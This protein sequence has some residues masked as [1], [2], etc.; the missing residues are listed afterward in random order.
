[1]RF[2]NAGWCGNNLL[3]LKLGEGRS[4]WF[5]LGE[6]RE[7]MWR[8]GFKE[9]RRGWAIW[10]FD[11]GF[12]KIGRVHTCLLQSFQSSKKPCHS[13]V[14]WCYKVTQL[15]SN[16][17]FQNL[18]LSAS[19]LINFIFHFFHSSSL[20]RELYKPSFAGFLDIDLSHNRKLS[21][22]SLVSANN[23]MKLK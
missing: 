6:G 21:L 14:L 17:P 10:T 19:F 1:M 23:L 2:C 8:K 9:W 22:R 5:K 7:C 18:F 20:K 4:I 3:I 11:I 12:W 15:Y 16:L 13:H